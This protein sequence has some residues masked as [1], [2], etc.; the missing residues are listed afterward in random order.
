MGTASRHE[1]LDCKEGKQAEFLIERQ[2]P[3]EL[4]SRI[5]VMTRGIHDEVLKVQQHL[6]HKPVVEIKPEWY[7]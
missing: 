4:V 1:G 7:Y 2:F 5:G 6:M 3:W